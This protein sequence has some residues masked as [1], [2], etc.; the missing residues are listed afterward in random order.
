MLLSVQNKRLNVTGVK[1]NE[2]YYK[3]DKCYF[4]LI[5]ASFACALA[6]LKG[7]VSVA[8]ASTAAVCELSALS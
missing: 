7:F 2:A 8:V 1:K 6:F 3:I 4:V 5:V